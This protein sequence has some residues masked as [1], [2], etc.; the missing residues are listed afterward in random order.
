[1]YL[2]HE[3]TLTEYAGLNAYLMKI[4]FLINGVAYIM[5]ISFLY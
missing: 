1:M 4:S 3:Q 2:N 5:E